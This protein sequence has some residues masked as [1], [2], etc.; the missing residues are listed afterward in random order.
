M[1]TCHHHRVDVPNDQQ[2]LS[3]ATD[4]LAPGTNPSASSITNHSASA[5]S[6]L[7]DLKTTLF[8]FQGIDLGLGAS[9][10]G[11]GVSTVA[12]EAEFGEKVELGP[13]GE[14]GLTDDVGEKEFVDVVRVGRNCLFEWVVLECE[15]GLNR[16][17]R[18]RLGK[19]LANWIAGGL[20]G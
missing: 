7:L 19:R 1:P 11:G 13:I 6:A 20:A 12:G 9:R 5:G 3:A 16:G 10:C 2:N 8:E 15:T 4:S 17:E 14:E 18:R